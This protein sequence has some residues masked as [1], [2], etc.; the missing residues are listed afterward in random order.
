VHL[1]VKRILTLSKCTVQQQQQ[2]QQ[3]QQ[4]KSFNVKEGNNR[5]LFS[6]SKHKQIQFISKMGI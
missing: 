1:L 6:M 2:Q 3:K 4:Q 5:Y